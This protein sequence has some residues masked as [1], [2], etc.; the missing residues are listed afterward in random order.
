MNHFVPGPLAFAIALTVGCGSVATTDASRPVAPPDAAP[1]CAPG[2]FCWENPKPQGD[3]L[4]SVWI[5]DAT[6]GFAVGAHGALLRLGASGW[7]LEPRPT[8]LDL[9][10]LYGS[11][12]DDIWAVAS[13]SSDPPSD[14][15]PPS[16]ALLHW[17]GRA[18]TTMR[19][20]G[21]TYWDLSGSA[22]DD[23]W[24]LTYRDADTVLL[25]WDGSA[26]LPAVLPGPGYSLGDVCAGGPN[27]LWA[28]AADETQTSWDMHILHWDG[29]AWTVSFSLPGEGLGP[30]FN[31]GISCGPGTDVWAAV[32]DFGTS[33][34]SAMQGAGGVWQSVSLPPAI[35][36]GWSDVYTTRVAHDGSFI[37]LD[38]SQ[39][40]IA[41]YD[42]TAG[43]DRAPHRLDVIPGYWWIADADFGADGAGWL[44]ATSDL[45]P[46]RG[47][48]WDTSGAGPRPEVT[49]L[50][51]PRG[52]PPAFAVGP[53]GAVGRR[54][55]R[56]LGAEAAWSFGAAAE[57]S[58]PVGAAWAPSSDDLWFAEG[59]T[60]I[61][62]ANGETQGYALPHSHP[63]VGFYGTSPA[64]LWV[65]DTEGVVSA[66]D[67]SRWSTLTDSFP[68]TGPGSTLSLVPTGLWAQSSSDLWVSANAVM[69]VAIPCGARTNFYGVVAHWNGSTW[70]DQWLTGPAGPPA[71]GIDGSS[72]TDLWILSDSLW[73]RGATGAWIEASARVGAS[74]AAWRVTSNGVY[75][76]ISSPAAA[77]SFFDASSGSVASYPVPVSGAIG[78]LSLWVG[79]TEVGA[80]DSIWV[81]G[82]NASILR[83]SP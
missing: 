34:N 26:W 57:S 69:N 5:Q 42:G 60:I 79:P 16:G 6:T 14:A 22:P 35:A 8:D 82:D 27:D 20:G 7:A 51:G 41:R 50:V 38:Y 56:G 12:P 4:A 17:D 43:D 24:V 70:T 11:G 78:A 71:N 73:H 28:I 10:G 59:A 81:G 2:T 65:I 19:P 29:S 63:I 66:W 32:Y 37:L 15:G 67:G 13:P 55:A 1:A 75:W 3:L 76:L 48:Q 68:A 61:H 64:S 77:V 58:Q 31:G 33:Q 44:A 18:W 30:R 54:S 72:A 45:V 40:I 80:P 46:W 49:G 36:S 39:G 83:R 23:A 47:T 62:D 74:V 52:G 53:G 9:S 25:H 21:R